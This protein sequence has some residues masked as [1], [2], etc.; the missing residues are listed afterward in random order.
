MCS[1]SIRIF[2]T[3]QLKT[4]FYFTKT[5]LRLLLFMIVFVCARR[6]IFR[7]LAGTI[8]SNVWMTSYFTKIEIALN[9][10]SFLSKKL[11]NY[12]VCRAQICSNYDKNHNSFSRRYLWHE[13]HF[14]KKKKLLIEINQLYTIFNK[15]EKNDKAKK[16]KYNAQTAKV[17]SE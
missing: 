7:L 13:L 17:F 4:L 9:C 2:I 11:I 16:I 12:K 5:R 1:I 10:W 6:N 8:T 15:V 3:H 14:R